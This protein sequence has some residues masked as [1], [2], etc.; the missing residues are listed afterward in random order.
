[1]FVRM[2]MLG[3]DQLVIFYLG[4]SKDFMCVLACHSQIELCGNWNFSTVSCIY[5]LRRVAQLKSFD[6]FVVA[7]LLTICRWFF[8]SDLIFQY[9]VLH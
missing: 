6:E 3:L 7:I 5:G 9:V 2:Y 4:K 1:M 8:L